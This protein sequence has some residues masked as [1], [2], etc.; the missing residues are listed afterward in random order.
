MGLAL[1]ENRNGLI[2]GAVATRASGHAERLTSVHLIA[3][4]ADRPTSITFGA[5]KGFDARGFVAEVRK[6]NGI[7]HLARNTSGRCSAIDG[8]TTR[9]PGYAL[10][11]R[12]HKRIEEAFGWAKTVAGL[13]RAR[14]RRHR[15]SPVPRGSRSRTLSFL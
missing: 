8:R 13:R 1:L 9:H 4:H 7:P 14:H 11:Q 12:I 6:V 10:S 5:A 2:V 3:L 15:P